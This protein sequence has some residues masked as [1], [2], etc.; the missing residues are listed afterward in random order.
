METKVSSVN[1]EVIIGHER[2]T[3]L[4]GERMNP[5]GKKTGRGNTGFP[6]AK[7]SLIVSCD[8]PVVVNS[9]RTPVALNQ[10]FMVYFEE[11]CH[12]YTIRD[13]WQITVN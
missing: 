5:T 8:L 3:V 10:P 12:S 4:I 11:V 2:P 13:S 1:K 7:P 9:F 6:I